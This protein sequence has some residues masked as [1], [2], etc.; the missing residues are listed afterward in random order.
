MKGKDENPTYASASIIECM[1]QSWSR[2]WLFFHVLKSQGKMREALQITQILCRPCSKENKQSWSADTSTNYGITEFICLTFKMHMIIPSKG[3]A[4]TND[5]DLQRGHKT[6]GG[7]ITQAIRHITTTWERVILRTSLPP[8]RRT[9]S[10]DLT[11][12]SINCRRY[13]S[14]ACNISGRLDKIKMR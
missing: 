3:I 13:R 2:G 12:R 7:H 8:A 11:I 14:K 4:Q 6:C 1:K 10:W 5:R 9:N